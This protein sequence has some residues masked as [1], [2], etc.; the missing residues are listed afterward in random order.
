MNRDFCIT[1]KKLQELNNYE[2]SNLF[3]PYEQSVL[4]Y[5]DAMT[6]NPAKVPD[7]VLENTV[8]F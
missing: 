7:N 3:S 2:N 6:S 4:Q 8:N 1:E 5:V